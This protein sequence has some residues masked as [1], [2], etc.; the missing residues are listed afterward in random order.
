MEELLNAVVNYLSNQAD[1][2]NEVGIDQES[3]YPRIG[4]YAADIPQMLPYLSV[5][6]GPTKPVSDSNI[7]FH[8][9]LILLT[10]H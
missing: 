3:S 2:V 7:Q 1:I 4:A 6:F 9:T 8:K 10:T 5:R